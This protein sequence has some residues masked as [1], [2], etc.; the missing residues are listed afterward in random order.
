MSDISSIV[1]L[2][3]HG[4]VGPV[5]RLATSAVYTNGAAKPTSVIEVNPATTDRVELSN[6][7]RWLGMLNSMSS[8]RPDRIAQVR[9]AIDAGTYLTTDKLNQAIDKMVQEEQLQ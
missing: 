2:G 1:G 7:A 8:V 9:Q 4:S 3:A 5:N 6:H